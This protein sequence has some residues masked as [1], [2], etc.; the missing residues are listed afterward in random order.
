MNEQQ[1]LQLNNM[2]TENNVLDQTDLMRSLKH[3]DLFRME[4]STMM[5]IKSKFNQGVID[6]ETMNMECMQ[7]CNFLFTYYTD[8]YH[9]LKKDE[10]DLD[11]FYKFLDVLKKIEDGKIDQHEGSFEIG[12]ILKKIYIDS[13]LKKAQ[14]NEQNVSQNTPNVSQ[15]Q[16][17]INISWKEYKKKLCGI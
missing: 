9:K 10:L 5:L 2:I 8:I 14:T 12:T 15:S 7:E 3:S 13:A 6:A 4:I 16:N 17:T 1:K 11:L